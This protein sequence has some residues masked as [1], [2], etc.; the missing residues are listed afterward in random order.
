MKLGVLTAVAAAALVAGAYPIPL[1]LLGGGSPLV[2]VETVVQHV[3][4]LTS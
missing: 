4:V 2:D 3:N 1:D